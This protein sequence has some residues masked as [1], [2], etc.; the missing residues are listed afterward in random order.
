ML[1]YNYEHSAL[2]FQA[3]L[4]KQLDRTIIKH[5]MGNITI[6]GKAQPQQNGCQ[7]FKKNKELKITYND[8]N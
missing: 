7:G 8:A 4:C 5:G 6:E 2:V 3:A 1:H